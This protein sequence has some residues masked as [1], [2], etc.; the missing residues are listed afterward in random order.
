MGSIEK[1]QNHNFEEIWEK[2]KTSVK[3]RYL[4]NHKIIN[5]RNDRFQA[6]SDGFQRYS[7]RRYAQVRLPK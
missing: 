6:Q 2:I 4:A 3:K 7:S 5:R 1:L